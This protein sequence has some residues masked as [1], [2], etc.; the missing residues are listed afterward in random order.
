MKEQLQKLQSYHTLSHDEAFDLM[1]SLAS[2]KIPGSVKASVLSA[3]LMR[4]PSIDEIEGFCD[5]LLS[6]C[7][8]VNLEMPVM[9]VCGTG[10]DGKDTFNISTLTAFVLAGCGIKI[11]KHGNYGASSV[12]G[13]SNVME[14]LGYRFTNDLSILK[15][16]LDEANICFLHAPLFHPALKNVASVRKELGIKT[17]FNILGPLVNPARP[18]FQ[19]SGVYS[20]EVARVYHYVL[21]RTLINYSV[22]HSFDG[23]DEVSLTCPAKILRRNLDCTISPG[24]FQLGIY[25][26]KDLNNGGTLDEAVKI[27]VNTLK[28]D[29]T[30]A[31]H[32]VVIANAA[33]ALQC[34]DEKLSLR[35][36]VET[37]NESL[38]TGSAFSCFQKLIKA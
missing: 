30:K 34:F 11:A 2:E 5:A 21:Q 14:S 23:Y 33:V 38:K 13:S 10:G 36:A 24:Q 26:A 32:N 9:D 17:L 12:C 8:P 16:Q 7:L 1:C 22:I 27:F 35:D 29:G 28:G 15:K 20:M 3:F 18:Q 37:A 6:L 4:S 31:R 25:Q 19:S